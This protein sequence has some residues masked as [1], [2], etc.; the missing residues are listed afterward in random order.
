MGKLRIAWLKVLIALRLAM[1][2]S[3]AVL[4]FSM[5]PA[6]AHEGSRAVHQAS[7]GMEHGDGPHHIAAHC[8]PV[9]DASSANSDTDSGKN[10]LK[11]DCCTASCVGLAVLTDSYIQHGRLTAPLRGLAP[12]HQ[13]SPGEIPN[14]KRPPKA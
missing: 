14:L 2:L 1:M 11:Q 9:A 5:S 3:L 8:A 7:A 13:V 4:H 10:S 6:M 12:D